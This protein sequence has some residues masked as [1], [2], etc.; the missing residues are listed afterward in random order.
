MCSMEAAHADVH[1]GL[2]DL[3]PIMPRDLDFR[4]GV[5]LGSRR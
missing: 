4:I 3:L 5:Y 2:A 1:N